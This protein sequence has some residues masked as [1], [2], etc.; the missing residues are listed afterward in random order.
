MESNYIVVFSTVENYLNGYQIA[1]VLVTER[2]AACCTILQNAI[3]IYE[4]EGKI[5]ERKEFVLMIKTTQNKFEELK[6]RIKE[7][8]TDKVPEILAI[9]IV[10][11]LEEYLD[12]VSQITSS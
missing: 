11:G 7:L 2:L 10:Q 8:H 4:W 6:H 12:W 9:P 1:K 3:S 5:D